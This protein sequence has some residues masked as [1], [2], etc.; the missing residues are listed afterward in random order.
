MIFFIVNFAPQTVMV[1]LTFSVVLIP[2]SLVTDVNRWYGKT[3]TPSSL[4]QSIILEHEN[5]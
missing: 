5:K 1:K 3:P 2:Y 4:A